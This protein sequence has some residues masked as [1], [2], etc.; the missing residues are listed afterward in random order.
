MLDDLGLKDDFAK[1]NN[2]QKMDTTMLIG[3]LVVTGS[4]FCVGICLI[5]YCCNQAKKYGNNGDAN[6]S[7]VGFGGPRVMSSRK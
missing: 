7:Q 3:G 6:K 4:L 1:K 2:G 5:V